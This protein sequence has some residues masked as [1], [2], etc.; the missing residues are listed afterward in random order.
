MKIFTVIIIALN[1]LCVASANASTQSEMNEWFQ[2]ISV[3]D[4]EKLDLLLKHGADIDAKDTV[5]MSALHHAVI[6]RNTKLVKYLVDH[7]AN[8]NLLREK[9]SEEKQEMT[10]LMF[11]ILKKNYDITKI[12][13]E[14]GADVNLQRP[15]DH[16][17]PLHVAAYVGD[18]DTAQFLLKKGAHLNA[19]TDNG[20]TALRDAIYGRNTQMVRF[21]LEQGIEKENIAASSKRT[22]LMLAA[23]TN[24]LQAVKLLIYFKADPDNATEEGTAAQAAAIYNRIDIVN[25]LENPKLNI[26]DKFELGIDILPEIS[27]NKK[28]VREENEIGQTLLHWAI[29]LGKHSLVQQLI[30]AGADINAQDNAQRTPL[31]Y[32]IFLW[33]SQAAKILIEHGGDLNKPDIN[34]ES[35][36]ALAKRRNAEEIKKLLEQKHAVLHSIQLKAEMVMPIGHQGAIKTLAFSSDGK[37]F[38]S[39]SE[40]QTIILWDTKTWKKHILLRSYRSCSFS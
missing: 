3:A 39:A 20:V 11:S 27:K 31:F 23:A 14:H 1:F 4:I 24:N 25:F 29:Y 34:G 37:Y 22:P 9:S 32:A 36:L 7:H 17:T 5:F 30:Q 26:F 35:P 13:I 2:A 15:S 6:D 18:I 28:L 12:L 10:P 21:L 40:D 8:V 33:N 16:A 38:V 19:K